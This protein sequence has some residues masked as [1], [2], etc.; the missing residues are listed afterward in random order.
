MLLFCSICNGQA[1]H[2]KNL[3]R[4]QIDDSGNVKWIHIGTND[5]TTISGGSGTTAEVKQTYGLPVMSGTIIT[6][7]EIS[8][9]PERK[10]YTVYGND[11]PQSRFSFHSTNVDTVYLNVI[12]L[13]TLIKY[14]PIIATVVDTSHEYG[15]GVPNYL[16]DSCSVN[17]NVVYGWYKGKRYESVDMGMR[18]KLDPY[19]TMLYDVILNKGGDKPIWEHLVY[20]DRTYNPLPKNLAV[21]Q[22]FQIK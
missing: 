9:I 20:F 17:M 21:I 7:P 18:E 22:T 1:I 3:K 15:W 10:R 4:F 11:E 2:S 5:S 13:D 8:D 12:G 6:L 14:V 16:I 19:T